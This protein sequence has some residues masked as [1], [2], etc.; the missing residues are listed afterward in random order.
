MSDPQK[1]AVLLILFYTVDNIRNNAVWAAKMAGKLIQNGQILHVGISTGFLSEGQNELD[2]SPFEYSTWKGR[3][4]GFSPLFPSSQAPEQKDE[5]NSYRVIV[6]EVFWM[7]LHPEVMRKIDEQMSR[8][9]FVPDEKTGSENQD[10]PLVT[11]SGVIY[12]TTFEII[13]DA[14][15]SNTFLRKRGLFARDEKASLFDFLK[16]LRLSYAD[17][18]AQCAQICSAFVLN[19]VLMGMNV[20][21]QKRMNGECIS[22]LKQTL[23]QNGRALHP[24]ELYGNIARSKSTD[25]TLLFNSWKQGIDK[26]SLYGSVIQPGEKIVLVSPGSCTDA[27]PV[28]N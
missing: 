11:F 15:L 8:S 17:G 7:P 24:G 13:W 3:E 27:K 6:E 23:I 22:A 9:K 16:N 5:E 18:H 25:G 26:V 20:H 10:Q 19:V 28:C 1:K 2:I 14:L 21:G 4:P 12:P